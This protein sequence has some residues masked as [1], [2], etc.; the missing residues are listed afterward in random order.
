MQRVFGSEISGNAR[1]RHELS[2]D[3]RLSIITMHEDG[4]SGRKIASKIGFGETAVRNCINY[5]KIMGQ[6]DLAK[7]PSPVHKVHPRT[8]R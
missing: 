3:Q 6:I 1:R 7:R 2:H 4:V 5:Y 8:E